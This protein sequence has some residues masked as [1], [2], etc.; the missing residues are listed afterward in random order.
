MTASFA[1][2][3]VVQTCLAIAG[4]LILAL[5]GQGALAL[6]WAVGVLIALVNSGLLVWRWHQGRRVIT[7]DPGRHM[8]VF[9]RSMVERYV[10]L[11]VLL[12]GA[13]WLHLDARFLL[14]GFIT[15]QIGWLLSALI[16]RKKA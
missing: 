5:L 6:A 16:W 1:W 8:R 12:G 3:L 15:G 10:G 14:A 13:L 9:Y 11:V 7:S 4:A 2:G